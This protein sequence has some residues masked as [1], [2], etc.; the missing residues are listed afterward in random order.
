VTGPIPD[1]RVEACGSIPE[2]THSSGRRHRFRRSAATSPGVC[3]GRLGGGQ[4]RARDVWSDRPARKPGGDAHDAAARQMLW[5]FWGFEPPRRLLE[6]LKLRR[7]EFHPRDQ[8]ARTTTYAGEYFVALR[9]CA[10]VFT[11][12]CTPLRPFG[13]VSGR[14]DP[15]TWEGCTSAKQQSIHARPAANGRE[16]LSTGLAPWVTLR[17]RVRFRRRRTLGLASG[18]RRA[19][20]A[21]VLPSARPASS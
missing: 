12:G 6:E 11:R 7:R 15:R 18:R 10:P 1:M 4:L 21:R 20:C 5:A 17:G 3:V 8:S 13:Y 16:K 19:Q 9:L 14:S 2:P